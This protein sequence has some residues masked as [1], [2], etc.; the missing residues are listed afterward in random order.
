MSLYNEDLV[1]SYIGGLG[2][3]TNSFYGVNYNDKHFASKTYANLINEQYADYR[4][5]FL[6]YE[7][8]LMSLADSTQLLDEQLSRVTTNVNQSYDNIG[9]QQAIMNQRYGLSQSA[10]QQKSQARNTDINRALSMAHAKNNTRVAV[11]DMQTGIL[12]GASAG[13]QSFQQNLGG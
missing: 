10:D 11:S 5:R 8:R 2:A 7:Q 6:P 12:T 13:Q 3:S 4:E 9:Q 1:N